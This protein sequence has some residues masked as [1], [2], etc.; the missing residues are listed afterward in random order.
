MKIEKR[1]FSNRYKV[2]LFILAINNLIY[3]VEKVTKKKN[4]RSFSLKIFKKQANFVT[5]ILVLRDG[6]IDC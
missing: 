1:F 3:S 6:I 5:A 2:R 4:V